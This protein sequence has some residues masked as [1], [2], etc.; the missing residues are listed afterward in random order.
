M[1]R[2]I[3]R[4]RKPNVNY[5]NSSPILSSLSISPKPIEK[6]C[7]KRRITADHSPR[8]CPAP[9]LSLQPTTLQQIP[10]VLPEASQSIPE[11]PPVMLELDDNYSSSDEAYTP[12]SG[13]ITN[14]H[15]PRRPKK[16]GKKPIQIPSDLPKLPTFTPLQSIVASHKAWNRLPISFAQL[17]K[18]EPIQIFN[19]FLTDS[20]MEQLVTNTNAYAE[21]QLKGPEKDRQRDWWPVT[22]K[23]LRCW[24][25][26]Q[27]HMG[28]LGVP[29]ER[30]WMKDGTYLP[31]EGLPPAAYLGK[32]RFQEIRR[33]FHVSPHDSPSTSESSEGGSSL[34]LWHSKVD[35]LL[36]QL[37]SFSQQYR[38]PG[39]NVTIDEAMILFTG[40]SIHITKM[41]N[42]PISQGYKFFC[43]AE[44]G[45]VWEFHPSS[46][47]V[48]GDPVDVESRLLP[49]TDTGKMVHHMVRYLRLRHRKLSFNI[50]M[51]NFFTTQPL[52]AELRRMG[53][54]ACG[55]CRPHFRGF[56]KELRV[57]KKAKLP[58]HFRNGA[59]ID[60]VAVLLWMDSAPVTMMSTIHPLSGEESLVSKMRK[61]PG[62]KS[63]NAQGANSVF[64]PG[65]RQKELDI[66]VIVH[67]YNL[68][69]VGVDVADQYR[70][71]FDT[72]LISR[73]NWYPLFYWILETALI[74]SLI[75]YRD[76][77]DNKSKHID[78]FDF[79]LSIV[80]AL[81]DADSTPTKKNST[82]AAAS[83]N[84][85]RAVSATQTAQS[86]LP[87]RR[88]TKSTPLPLSRRIPG[89]HSPLW[90]ESRADCFLCRWRR[91]QGGDGEPMKTSIKCEDCNEALCFTPQRNCFYEFHHM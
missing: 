88:V 39:T 79:C 22:G 23:E 43:L 52:L 13:S 40:R 25:A 83:S 33:F 30:Y 11:P 89:I 73:R 37:R 6:K 44:K 42:K 27:I 18:I 61:H 56:P 41:P 66:P 12:V 10:T 82:R 68:H 15:S 74:N 86:P 2:K 47:A 65:E 51:D 70:T 62:N 24:L 20:I 46:N 5:Q 57:G 32:T 49:L 28:L 14:D 1:N 38:V 78:H 91:S 31:K 19:L 81:L 48:G 77:P 72:Q 75:I 69:K 17:D 3:L 35:L 58:Y 7:A 87:T 55:T 90:M 67:E 8:N 64:L 21:Y 50:Y 34:P 63:T 45:Y 60:G 80:R 71:Y 84:I 9:Q 4:P 76:L 36:N 16:N 26:I 29:P 53:V 85:T 59:V 54:G